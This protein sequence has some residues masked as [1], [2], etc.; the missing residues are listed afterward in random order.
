MSKDH[1]AWASVPE[2]KEGVPTLGLGE[3]KKD[4]GEDEFSRKQV[5]FYVYG[6]EDIKSEFESGFTDLLNSRF[7]E[8]K[9]NWDL[10]TLYPTHSKGEVNP[11]MEELLKDL[12]AETGINYRRVLERTKN[13]RENHELDS[14][15]A[16]TVNLEG[17]I[18]AK[19]F[20]GENVILFDNITLSGT[21]VLHGVNK[22]I[23]NGA[24]N[25]FAVVLGIHE[26]FPDKKMEDRNKKASKLIQENKPGGE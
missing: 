24:E 20:D 14:Q 5:W 4:K 25:V 11:N 26:N 2:Y 3:Y 15:R 6:D 13:I 12:S 10:M 22:L 23:E 16:K 17:S 7:V 19:D 21:S 18:E 9:L 1:F 8:D